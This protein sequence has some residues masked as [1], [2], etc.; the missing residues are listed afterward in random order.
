[1]ARERRS[2]QAS[3]IA[4][5]VLC[6]TGSLLAARAEAEFEERPSRVIRALLWHFRD[7]VLLRSGCRCLG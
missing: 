7:F 5:S 1:M 2:R 3:R 4:A 6:D